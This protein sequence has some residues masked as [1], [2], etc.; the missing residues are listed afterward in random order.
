MVISELKKEILKLLSPR[1]TQLLITSQLKLTVTDY[2]LKNSMEVSGD[3]AQAIISKAIRIKNG[4]PLQYVTGSTEFMSLPFNVKPGVL[5]PRA[6]TEVLV[7]EIINLVSTQ[8]LSILEIGAGSGCIS[9]SIKK[10]CP[11]CSITA[12]DI[13]DTALEVSKGNAELNNVDIELIKKDILKDTLDNKYHIIVS[14]PP[15]IPSSHIDTLDSNVKDYE[16][17]ISLDGGE[18]G[19]TFYRHIT[20]IAPNHLYKGGYLFFEVGHDQAQSV[21]KLMQNDFTNISIKQDLCG[22]DRVVYGMINNK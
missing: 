12:I 7:E 8:N 17:I 21:Y 19:L 16:P 4:E 15:Y 3:E 10:Y 20:S 2:V 14:N 9:V 18:D 6:D 22:I 13:S 11:S 5:I 1:D